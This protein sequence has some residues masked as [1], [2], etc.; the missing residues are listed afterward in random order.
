MNLILI[1]IDIS[2]KSDLSSSKDTDSAIKQANP[3]LVIHL[4]AESHVDRS[5]FSSLLFKVTYWELLIYY[6]L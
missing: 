5:G 3:D 2:S 1:M 6:K 4:A